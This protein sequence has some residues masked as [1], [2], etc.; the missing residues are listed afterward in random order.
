MKTLSTLSATL[1]IASS[2]LTTANAAPM[3][4][5]MEQALVETCK[6]AASNKTIRFNNTLKAHR[7]DQQTVALGVVCNGEDIISFA[8]SKGAD[9]IAAQLESSVG[10]ASI[11]DIASTQIKKLVVSFPVSP[12]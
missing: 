8:Q 6:A 2:V 9:K 10:E 12:K 5:Y 4:D 3:S 11:T 1:V 7:L